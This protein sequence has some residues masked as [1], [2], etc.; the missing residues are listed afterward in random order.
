VAG[1]VPPRSG[2]Q[3]ID[4]AADRSTAPTPRAVQTWAERFDGAELVSRIVVVAAAVFVFV[5]LRPRLIFANTTPT[6]G[7]LG[8]HVLGPSLMRAHLF[9]HGLLASWSNDWFGGFPSYRFYP[10]LPALAVVTL[11]TILPY[12]V[13]LKIMVAVGLVAMPVVAWYFG[14][15][16]RLP[17]VVPGLMALA[18]LLVL[19]DS[20]N[21]KFG[22]SIAS[23]VI[24]EYADGLG[25]TLG[26]LCL[27]R[28]NSDLGRDRRLGVLAG[29]IGAAAALCHPIAAAFVVI[30]LLSLAGSQMLF[31]RERWRS[32][33]AHL[34]TTL[35][36]TVIIS[37]FWYLP[38]F[39]WRSYTNDLNNPPSHAF[40][41][42]FPL[43]WPISVLLV[44]LAIA[45]VVDAI[46]H[47]RAPV[48]GLAVTAVLFALWTFV[49]PKGMLWN[50]R[51]APLWF[52]TIA[53]VAAA[54]AGAA[55]D[56][57]RTRLDEKGRDR[58][59]G[60]VVIAGPV[61]LAVI[62]AGVAGLGHGCAAGDDAYDDARRRPRGHDGDSVDRRATPLT[63]PDPVDRAERVQ[64]LR[65]RRSLPP[66][67]IADIDDGASQPSVR[68]R[69]GHARVRSQW[70][71]RLGLRRSS[72]PLLDRRLHHDR[73]WSRERLVGH[74][75]LRARR[76]VGALEHVLGL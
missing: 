35:G 34:G 43:P 48:L 12:G 58:F 38:F 40:H 44:V 61:A 57:A 20:S 33:L 76:R 7:D 17:T 26:L 49:A 21:L 68:M 13:A 53:L 71:V 56:G 64:R 2:P 32:L 42:L 15:A 36:L 52:L 22:G 50:A 25:I 60:R 73:D 72:A 39:A 41:V 19:F 46:R 11:D 28:F 29:L 30:G 5:Y 27:A 63:E 55:I 9:G 16:A 75:G 74:V 65:A 45:G 8:G 3:P 70:N 37:A 24:G 69:S 51:L 59:V 62:G 66:I 31:E 4:T 23:A 67:H 47:Q 6:G 54:G 14:R 10:P 18:S 1:H